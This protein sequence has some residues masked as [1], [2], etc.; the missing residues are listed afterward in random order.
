MN[1]KTR[2]V[3]RQYLRNGDLNLAEG[4]I[5]YYSTGLGGMTGGYLPALPME[6]GGYLVEDPVT[7][8]QNILIQG[9]TKIEGNTQIDGNL[10]IDG[11]FTING[12]PFEGGGASYLIELKDVGRTE[13]PEI[14]SNN[15]ILVYDSTYESW[16][17]K[18]GKT[19]VEDIMENSSIITTITN[20]LVQLEIRIAALE[21][22]EFKTY[23]PPRQDWVQDDYGNYIWNTHI[24]MPLNVHVANVWSS[25]PNQDIYDHYYTAIGEVEVLDFYEGLISQYVIIQFKYSPTESNISGHYYYST[26]I[27]N[28]YIT[29]GHYEW[30]TAVKN[31]FTTDTKLKGQQFCIG[32]KHNSHIQRVRS[33]FQYYEG[34]DIGFGSPINDIKTNQVESIYTTRYVNIDSQTYKQDIKDNKFTLQDTY[35]YTYI[36]T[37]LRDYRDDANIT[38][39][40]HIATGKN[41]I[42]SYHQ[43]YEGD[44][45]TAP[46]YG[47]YLETYGQGYLNN[48]HSYLS[49]SG[50]YGIEMFGTSLSIGVSNGYTLTTDYHDGFLINGKK[51]LV[52]GS[53]YSNDEIYSKDETDTLL[54]NYYTKDQ[55]YSKQEIT[56]LLTNYYTK[57]QN[58]SKTEVDSLLTNLDIDKYY[59]KEE[60]DERYY[61]KEQSEKVASEI[62]DEKYKYYFIPLAERLNNVE[63]QLG[64]LEIALDALLGY[65]TY[66]EDT[67]DEILEG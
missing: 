27:E 11:E 2:N 7:F 63:E 20:K 42:D 15:S 38:G 37:F 9:D 49:M 22:A 35:T 6:E 41:V 54:T 56:S 34:S 58:Y 10:N 57:D 21:A 17:Y 28:I 39:K 50:I 43:V 59:K 5:S 31:L 40:V 4:G 46:Q 67:L 23:Y 45:G 51:I 24:V 44:S 48:M 19:Y 65:D 62:V 36:P 12:E 47:I 33:R 60:S 1:I 3:P 8:M 53:V 13:E 26:S 55:N 16:L 64:D 25:Y 52:E 30:Q 66:I 18:N 32:F 61:T 29:G 14:P